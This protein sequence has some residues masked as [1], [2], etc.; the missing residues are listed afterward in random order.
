MVQAF[1]LKKIISLFELF[2]WKNSSAVQT[3]P[4]IHLKK[5]YQP[6]QWHRLSIQEKNNKREQT[7]KGLSALFTFS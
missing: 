5:N 3:I 4:A 1:C 6:F 7:K 2:V